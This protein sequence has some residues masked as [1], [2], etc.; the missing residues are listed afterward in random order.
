MNSALHLYFSI[1]LTLFAY[2]GRKIKANFISNYNN[3][4]L[5]MVKGHVYYDGFERVEDV[6]ILQLPGEISSKSYNALYIF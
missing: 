4:I 6:H 1:F 3:C 2:E 5:I